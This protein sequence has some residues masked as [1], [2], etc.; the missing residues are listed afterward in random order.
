MLQYTM[1]F[2]TWNKT[3]PLHSNTWA[4]PR[5]LPISQFDHT[6]MIDLVVNIVVV[7]NNITAC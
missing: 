2:N 3:I 1:K 5:H 7:S 4:P 6:G